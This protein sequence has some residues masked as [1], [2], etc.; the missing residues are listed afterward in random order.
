MSAF[1]FINNTSPTRN[2]KSSLLSSSLIEDM[3]DSQHLNTFVN[4]SRT[5]S[6]RSQSSFMLPAKKPKP[7]S[8][9]FSFTDDI[10]STNKRSSNSS[11]TSLP[12]CNKKQSSE[13]SSSPDILK[14]S[15]FAFIGKFFFHA[16]KS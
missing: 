15:A 14:K 10:D 4:Q 11:E 9:Y 3:Y 1:G 5:S 2:N 12:L 7:V 13:A 8:S 16:K 6:P